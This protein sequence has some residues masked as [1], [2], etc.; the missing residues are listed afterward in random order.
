MAVNK[1]RYLLFLTEEVTKDAKDYLFQCIESHGL[2]AEEESCPGQSV[3]VVGAPF[4]RLCEEVRD[5]TGGQKWA[6]AASPVVS[7][8]R[9][10]HIVDF[11]ISKK[12]IAKCC[13]YTVLF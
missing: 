10:R 9:R 6:G 4:N 5:E 13:T 7:L 12:G 1:E 11:K 8:W 2:I 3:I